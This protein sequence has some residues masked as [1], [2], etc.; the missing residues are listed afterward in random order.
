MVLIAAGTL[1]GRPLA[2]PPG[3]P[4]DRVEAIRQAFL[5]TMTDPEFLKEAE[6]GNIEVEPVAGPRMQEVSADLIATPEAVKQRARPL[7]E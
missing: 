4:A 1:Y 5:A 7:I 6:A 2:L 3:V